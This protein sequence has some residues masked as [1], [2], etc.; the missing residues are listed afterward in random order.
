M[1]CNYCRHFNPDDSVYCNKCG[2]PMVSDGLESPGSEFKGVEDQSTSPAISPENAGNLTAVTP[3]GSGMTRRELR[4]LSDEE[5]VLL[6]HTP[7]SLTEEVRS[8]LPFEI[9]RRGIDRSFFWRSTL[10][11]QK[12]VLRVNWLRFYIYVSLPI[13]AVYL[14]VIGWGER[15]LISSLLSTAI[16]IL[17]LTVAYG[18]HN[19]KVWAWKCNWI[20]LTLTSIGFLLEPLL[21]RK[22]S[23]NPDYLLGRLIGGVA[24]GLLWFLLNFTYFNKRRT[25]FSM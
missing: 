5:L 24:I 4:Q 6:F 23:V 1:F 9:R 2:K 12:R 10:E 13:S 14:F 8:V 3:N 22:A 7:A 15:E 11:L 17:L 21:G 16:G 19:R 18:L 25:L 20:L